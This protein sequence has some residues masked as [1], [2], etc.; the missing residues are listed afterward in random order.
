M[1]K[2]TEG[3]GS[4]SIGQTARDYKVSSDREEKFLSARQFWIFELELLNRD[5][6]KP[7]WERLDA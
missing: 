2:K 7:W 4:D 3:A 1:S 5:Q 6:Y